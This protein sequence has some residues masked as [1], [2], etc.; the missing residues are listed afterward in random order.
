M[1]IVIIDYG[2]GNLRSV[3]NA[4]LALDFPAE[5]SSR[6]EDLRASDRIVLPG[7]G[8]FGD[9]MR[10]LELGGWIPVL[11]ETVVRGGRPLL[12]I[13]LGMHLLATTG[14]E[15]GL[16]QGLGWIPGVVERLLGDSPAIRVPHIG[17]NEVRFAK[18]CGLFAGLDQT[19]AF[20]FVH[21]YVLR[22]EDPSVVA[23]TTTHGVEFAAAIER[24][25]V[26]GT[27]FHPEKSQKA[28]LAVLRCFASQKGT[29]C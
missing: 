12:G 1:K 13:C 5:V 29:P 27:Q 4:F 19:Q 18:A 6:P 9:G 24:G 8:A 7:V 23:G 16:R 2:M 20:Y 11:E 3:A 26:W 25:N 22:P 10:N 15:G 14:T 21:S 28:G 17:W